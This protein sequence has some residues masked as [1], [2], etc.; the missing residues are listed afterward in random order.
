MQGNAPGMAPGPG[1]ASNEPQAQPAT[2]PTGG[3]AP[4]PG[5]RAPRLALVLAVVAV[6]LGG[7]ALAVSLLRKPVSPA[8]PTVVAS[9]PSPTAPA[10]IFD[11]DADRAL[12]VEIAP[13]MKEND[14]R[15]KQFTALEA[16]SPEQGAAIPAYRTFVEDWGRRTQEV[17][18]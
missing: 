6:L 8:A 13:L 17:L 18:K 3:F 5:R 1:P 10:Q 4:A 7:A 12:C 15:G 9:P 2:P 16:G 11:P 14:D